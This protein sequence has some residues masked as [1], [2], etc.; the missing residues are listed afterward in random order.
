GCRRSARDPRRSGADA[1]G[2][3]VAIRRVAYRSAYVRGG[4]GG[5]DSGRCA[6]RLLAGGTCGTDRADVRVAGELTPFAHER[7]SYFLL[8]SDIAHHVK[9]KNRE[10]GK[11]GVRFLKH[12]VGAFPRWSTL[13]GVS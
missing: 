12:E 9:L 5:A 10:Y 7:Q 8:N 11:R 2:V 1:P 13:P 3:F 6:G 4:G